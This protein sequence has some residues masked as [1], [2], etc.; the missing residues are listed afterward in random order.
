MITAAALQSLPGITHGFFTREGGVS[1]GLYAS[2][3]IGI[4][5]ADVAAD[6]MT[7]RQL[8]A[9]KLGLS[10]CDL[11]LPYQVHSANVIVAKAAWGPGPGPKADAVVT[12]REGTGV[13]ISTADCA[14][15]LFAD[16]DAGVIGAAHAGWKGALTGVLEATVEAMESLGARRR[17]TVAVVGP[18]I[19]AAAYEVGPEFV[20]RFTAA[21]D[22][23]KTFFRPSDRSGHA[24]FD[25]PGYIRSRLQQLDLAII[26]NLGLCTYADEG[27]FYSYR[28]ATHRNEADYGR[29]LSAIC[30]K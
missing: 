11:S 15:V 5:S 12:D 9:A 3:N 14:P 25:L 24:M 10:A 16:S 8:S 21:G 28:R 13:G 18:T 27:R 2:M 6:V 22:A 30:L 17:T 7:N 19:S 23:N 4:G 20:E 26:N 29:L 1:G